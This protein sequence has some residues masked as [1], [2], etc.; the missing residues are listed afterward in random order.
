MDMTDSWLA[1]QS[2]LKEMNALI[3]IYEALT[4]VNVLITLSAGVLYDG[5]FIGFPRDRTC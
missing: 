1:L 3:L 4:Y 5:N 2:H